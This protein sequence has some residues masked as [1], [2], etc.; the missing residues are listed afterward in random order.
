MADRES[1]LQKALMRSW[2]KSNWLTVMLWPLS[3]LYRCLFVVREQLYKR[4]VLKRFTAPIPVIVVGN[5][6]VGGTGKT[7]MVIH[8]VECLREMGYKPGVISRGYG[9]RA[10][11]YP[12]LLDAATPVENCG[13][14][15]ALIVK[16]TGVP[17]VV[18]PDRA[19]DIN[20]LLNSADID[21]I[22]SDDGLQHLALNRNIEICLIDE[23]S[24]HKNKCLLPAGP[25]RE[26]ISRL[27][28]VDLVV[29]HKATTSPAQSAQS[30]FSST[31]FSMCLVAEEPQP[32]NRH[33]QLEDESQTNP[34]IFDT[35][36]RLHAVAG[37]GNPQRFFDTCRELGLSFEEHSFA[38]HHQFSAADL[39]FGDSLAVL[40]TEK[41]A[42]KCQSL[43]KPTHWYLPVDAKLSDGFVVALSKCLESL[44]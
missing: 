20:L 22:V 37:I 30:Q 24:V 17:M 38:D 4:G 33:P 9:G 36:K 25:W 35:S 10:P 21:V 34:A 23:T 27:N 5:L 26:P 7:P 42:V 43:A 28:S 13:D 19:A 16:R 2:Q 8:L 40:M 41:D 6:T 12:L 29:R 1:A 31:Q 39:E 11:A 18:G 44:K 14:E 32:V 15:P 3:L